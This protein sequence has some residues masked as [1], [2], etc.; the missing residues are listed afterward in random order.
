[1]VGY[2]RT[3]SVILEMGNIS[4]TIAF[5]LAET[6]DSTASEALSKNSFGHLG[7]TGTSL[8]IEPSSERIFVLLTNRTHDRELPFADLKV[9]RQYF[10]R[11]AAEILDGK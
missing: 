6:P 10:H 4:D 1:M 2:A 11:L 9:T 3:I 8:W 5:Q 7:F